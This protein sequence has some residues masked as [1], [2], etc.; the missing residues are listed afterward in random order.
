MDIFFTQ[1]YQYILEEDAESASVHLLSALARAGAKGVILAE[2]GF[3][4]GHP[5]R[6]T[7]GTSFQSHLAY[8]SGSIDPM[9]PLKI[10]PPETG[11]D[12]TYIH[13]T[14]IEIRIR[15]NLFLVLV[16]YLVTVLLGL[17]LFGIELFRMVNYLVRLG[18]FVTIEIFIVWLIFYVTGNL[19]KR[20]DKVLLSGPV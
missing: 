16:A 10:P 19:K 9:A 12:F 4:L 20:L 18:L 2:N 13:R 15:P 5:W 17:D 7:P 3:R 11:G 14:S 1:R 6:L 8:L